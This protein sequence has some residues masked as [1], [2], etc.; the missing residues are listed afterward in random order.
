MSATPIRGSKNSGRLEWARQAF[1]REK[2]FGMFINFLASHL[3]LE[4]KK[5]MNIATSFDS[6]LGSLECFKFLLARDC[7]AKHESDSHRQWNIGDYSKS[8]AG[9][10]RVVCQIIPAE[11]HF[12]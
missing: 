8:F 3:P 9:S 5:Q 11:F 7:L 2:D 12:P 6:F 10:Y 4:R 1:V